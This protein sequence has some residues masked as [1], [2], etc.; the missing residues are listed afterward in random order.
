MIYSFL[1]VLIA[2]MGF[3]LTEFLDLKIPPAFSL[4]FASLIATIFFNLI[5]FR[6]LRH[7]YK[8]CWEQ[9]WL[10]LAIMVTILVMWN[11]TMIGPGLIGASLYSFLY[12]TWLGMLGFFSLCLIDWEKNYRKF[13]FGLGALI[14]ILVSVLHALR[15]QVSYNI[16]F[17][18]FLSIVGGTSSFIYFKQS[19]LLIKRIQLTATQILGV[20]F[21]LTIIISFVLIPKGNFSFYLTRINLLEI[22]FLAFLTL[23]APLFFMQKALEKISAEQNAIIL[24]LT[25]CVAAFLQALFFKNVTIV[26]VAIYLLYTLLVSLSYFINTFKSKGGIAK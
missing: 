10:Y 19:Q 24:S 6:K 13:Y 5:N 25:P 21:Y 12:F 16:G 26:D 15:M 4:F 1:Y 2:G 7:M 8:G 3:V 23:I 14:L 17:G 18:I 22:T 20:R 9:K 11:C